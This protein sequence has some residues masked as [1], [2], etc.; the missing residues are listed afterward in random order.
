VLEFEDPG[1][2]VLP[3]AKSPPDLKATVLLAGYG[4]NESNTIGEKRYAE[5]TLVA[6]DKDTF[7]VSS[8]GQNGAC[9]GDSGGPL[10]VGDQNAGYAIAGVLSEGS[11]SCR[12]QDV[13][14]SIFAVK[15][16]LGQIGAL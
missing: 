14:T 8:D 12:A 9:V 16:W 5:S 6:A 2:P 15:D 1:G 3:L 13:Y 4:L 11:L 10:F 7:T